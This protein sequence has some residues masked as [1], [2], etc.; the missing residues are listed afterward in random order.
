MAERLTEAEIAV[1]RRALQ[2]VGSGQV[3]P[4]RGPR[5][6]APTAANAGTASGSSSTG[7]PSS[8]SSKCKIAL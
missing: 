1:V 8:V 3:E 6:A 5:V 2:I 7:T 4:E